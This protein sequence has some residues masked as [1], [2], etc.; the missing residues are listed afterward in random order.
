[1]GSPLFEDKR[2]QKLLVSLAVKDREFLKQCASL[3]AHKDFQNGNGFNPNAAIV[4]MA[5]AHYDKYREPVGE[6]LSVEAADYAKKHKLDEAKEE[7]LKDAVELVL[8]KKIKA[9]ASISEKVVQFKRDKLKQQAVL[10][11]SSL[12]GR[13]ELTDEKWLELSR[14]A[15]LVLEQDSFHVADYFSELSKRIQRRK[16]HTTSRF[17]VLFIDPLDMLVRAIAKGHVGLVLAPWKRGKSMLL[18]HI[19]LAYVLQRLNVLFLTLEDPEEDVEDRFDSA[20]A[21]LPIKDLGQYSKTLRKRFKYFTRLSRARLKI[22]D[23][24]ERDITIRKVEEIIDE[25]RNLGF[26]ADAVIIDY[27]DE[28]KPAKRYAERRMEFAEIY[29]DM[30][31]LASRRDLLVWTA[32]QTRRGTDQAKMI[33]G[34]HLAEDISKVRKVAFALGMGKG[35]WG[36][37]SIYLN[38]A[39][40]KFDKQHVGCHIISDKDR[41]LIFSRE[42]TARALRKVSEQGD[43]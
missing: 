42:K 5:L 34:D 7:S 11:M 24:T 28:I 41:M 22:V 21:Q 3:L 30:R 12:H 15:L 31:K 25:Q 18:I 19:A 4:K 39:A 35:D 36:D 17:P 27:D 43:V 38:V 14:K 6:L 40:H 26:I 16:Y 10:E 32:A 8:R 13:G 1:M 2:F 9:A 37:D 29:R 20:L 23:C 33:T